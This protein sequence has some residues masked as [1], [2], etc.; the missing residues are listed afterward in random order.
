MA[1]QKITALTEVTD[2]DDLD[3]CYIVDDPSGA[4]TSSKIRSDNLA[5]IA[6]GLVHRTDTDQGFALTSGV[7]AF[8]DAPNT[9]GGTSHLVQEDF[10]NGRLVIN[11]NGWY[12]CTLN[13]SF[14]APGG[15]TVRF[16]MN[17]NGTRR[18]GQASLKLEGSGEL[19]TVTLQVIA[20]VTSITKDL[21]IEAKADATVTLTV[22][23][24]VLSCA[25]I[26]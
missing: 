19:K 23:D 1:D 15:T 18:P 13:I 7:W 14:F 22:K 6:Y 8:V 9:V 5:R 11:R 4:P 26:G 25:R 24:C 16:A 12:L 2:V 21:R 17:W 20:N 10:A 3:V